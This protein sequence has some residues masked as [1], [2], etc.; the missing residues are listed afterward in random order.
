MEIANEMELFIQQ[1]LAGLPEIYI[2][3]HFPRWV[4][5]YYH[6][7]LRRFANDSHCFSELTSLS[8]TLKIKRA[9]VQL[10]GPQPEFD[11]GDNG[12]VHKHRDN[13]I[14]AQF[15]RDG[16]IAAQQS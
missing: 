7:R 9:I 16:E 12:H 13:N 4:P 8:L 10:D 14:H 1:S 5:G 6:S 3:R 15:W 2:S 11:H